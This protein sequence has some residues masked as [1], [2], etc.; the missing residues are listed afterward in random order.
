MNLL[1][2]LEFLESRATTEA[3][4]E[5]DVESFRRDLDAIL[6][7][8]TVDPPNQSVGAVAVLY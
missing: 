7:Q 1:G 6:F 3:L 5:A 8:V 2:V 4:S